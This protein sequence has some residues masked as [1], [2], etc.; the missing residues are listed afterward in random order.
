MLLLP[1]LNLETLCANPAALF[2]LAHFRSSCSP[3]EWA[4]WDSRQL[5]LSWDFGHF[6]HEFSPKCVAMYEAYYGEVV[7]WNA[8]QAHCGLILGYPRARYAYRISGQKFK[9]TC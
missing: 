8:A 6:D 5:D 9:L 4:A 3:A 2:A 1:W 7:N